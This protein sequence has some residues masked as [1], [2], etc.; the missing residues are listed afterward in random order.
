MD[1][2]E[3]RNELI[4]DYARFSR[5]FTKI[6]AD[7]IGAAVAD[8]YGQQYFW[9]APLIQINPSFLPGPSV[10]D[11]A[12]RGALHGECAQIFR[13]QKRE[14]SQGI[15]IR[16]HKHQEE[17]IACAQ[18][19]QSYV[20]T[21]GT[22]SGKSLAYF[23]PIVDAVLKAKASDPTPR[24]RAIIIYPMNALANS[25]REELSD[26]LSSYGEAAPVTFGRYTGQEDETERNR[27]ASDPPDILLTNFMMLEL[28]MTRQ[29]D[30]DR[31]VIRNA[32]GLE[33]LVLDELHTYRGRQG[34]DVAM[35][36]RR[37]LEVERI[38][39]DCRLAESVFEQVNSPRLVDGQRA[40]ALDRLITEAKLA[41]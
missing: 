33:F 35:L 13:K 36:V 18:K 16:L 3:F 28:L 34:A 4:K 19:R 9:P 8:I 15:S 32:H 31:A 30:K 40:A 21:T 11:L 6:R 37:V 41:A 17:A 24:T 1:A 20:L 23:I 2:F 38:S 12:N 5:S 29:D 27:L 7:D 22:G 26:Y 14:G 39:Q 25:Q 10:E